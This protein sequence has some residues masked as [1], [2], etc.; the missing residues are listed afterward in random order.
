MAARQWLAHHSTTV[1]RLNLTVS[2]GSR[3]FVTRRTGLNRYQILCCSAATV[4]I[5][6]ASLLKLSNADLARL[7]E[8]WIITQSNGKLVDADPVMG[9]IRCN[10]CGVRIDCRQSDITTYIDKDCWPLCCNEVMRFHR[11]R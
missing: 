6:L 2:A 5:A 8:V 10:E 11:K 4:T 3:C 9:L 7:I 1:A